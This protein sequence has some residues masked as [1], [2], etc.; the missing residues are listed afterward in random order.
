[1]ERRRYT[2]G[3][4]GALKMTMFRL[5][6]PR[7]PAV[8]KNVSAGGLLIEISEPLEAGRVVY[9]EMGFAGLQAFAEQ[10]G[11]APGAAKNDIIT[12]QARVV[13]TVH[14]K[15]LSAFG[16]NTGLEFVNMPQ[17][18][19]QLLDKFIISKTGPGPLPS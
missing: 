2:R 4:R 19:A 16:W 11:C 10:S 9:F 15:N 17:E 14:V 12:G 7:S 8:C 5:T 6:N 18:T 13:R 1:M 3:W